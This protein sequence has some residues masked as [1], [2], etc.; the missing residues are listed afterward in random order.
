MSISNSK[1]RLSVYENLS[2]STDIYRVAVNDCCQIPAI[3]SMGWSLLRGIY[4]SLSAQWAWFQQRVQTIFNNL[5]SKIAGVWQQLRRDYQPQYKKNCIG[6]HV[7]EFVFETHL[8]RERSCNTIPEPLPTIQRPSRLSHRISL[9]PTAI[10]TD[11][12]ASW[13]VN[14][15]STTIAENLRKSHP[16]GRSWT[17]SAYSVLT[18]AQFKGTIRL[19]LISTEW[20]KPC[21][22][23]KIRSINCGKWWSYGIGQQRMNIGL[24][25]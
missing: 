9:Q 3:W 19:A 25:L 22:H 5:L 23:I 20:R 24:R 7:N 13:K 21:I 14:V 17:C 2:Q 4:S 6:A 16:D 10:T 18:H 12:L 11:V 1:T 8:Q 15:I